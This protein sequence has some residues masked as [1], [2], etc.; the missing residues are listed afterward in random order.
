M[1]IVSGQADATADVRRA[2]GLAAPLAL[3]SVGLALA[4]AYGPDLRD[5]VAT[6][7]DDPDYSHGFLVIPVA[8]AILWQRLT[9][10]RRGRR[11]AGPLGLGGASGGPGRPAGLLRV[12]QDVAGDGH[13]AAG[14]WPRWR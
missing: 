6:W 1:T 5:L 11:P 8:L 9:A 14:A 12:R 13:A 3:A 7:A 4:W 2:G 10:P